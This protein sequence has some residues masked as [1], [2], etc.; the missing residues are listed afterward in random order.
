MPN[1]EIATM[2]VKK[3]PLI[4]VDQIDPGLKEEIKE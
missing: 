3:L 4:P 2:K 1:G